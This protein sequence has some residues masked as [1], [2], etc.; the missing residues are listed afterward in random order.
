MWKESN[1]DNIKAQ[2]LQAV[3]KQEKGQFHG[4]EGR[5]NL[6]WEK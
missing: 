1:K 6:P 4:F 3:I 5:T 2:S